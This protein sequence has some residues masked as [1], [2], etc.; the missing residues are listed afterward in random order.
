M[1]DSNLQRPAIDDISEDI[2]ELTDDFT[3]GNIDRLP[4]RG[5]FPNTRSGAKTYSDSKKLHRD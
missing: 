5:D 1:T 3:E 2:D 4:T